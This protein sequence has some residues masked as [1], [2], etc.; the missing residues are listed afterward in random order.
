LDLARQARVA[1]NT[2]PTSPPATNTAA[3]TPTTA[4]RVDEEDTCA[5]K[6][7]YEDGEEEAPAAPADVVTPKICDGEEGHDCGC[8]SDAHADERTG[9]KRASSCDAFEKAPWTSARTA[10][11]AASADAEEVSGRAVWDTSM[12]VSTTQRGG[13]S[14][15]RPPSAWGC[16]VRRRRRE[17]DGT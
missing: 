11:T 14:R 5:H 17:D 4:G 8:A 10:A 13:A 3:R 1:P 9:P 15:R 16:S 2:S 6:A 7:E 12:E